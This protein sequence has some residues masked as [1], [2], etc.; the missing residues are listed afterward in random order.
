MTVL[1]ED[2]RKRIGDHARATLQVRKAQS[3][4][5]GTSSPCGCWVIGSVFRDAVSETSTVFNRT[6]PLKD[7]KN[8]QI[9]LCHQNH[10]IKQG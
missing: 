9:L 3:F 5:L 7:G 2:E 10:H 1:A 6:S 4:Q 8:A